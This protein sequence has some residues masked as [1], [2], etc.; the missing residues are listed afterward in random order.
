MGRSILPLRTFLPLLPTGLSAVQVRN[1]WGYGWDNAQVPVY[2][3]VGKLVIEQMLHR[4]LLNFISNF[5][6]AKTCFCQK[7]Q[8][9]RVVCSLKLNRI[10]ESPGEGHRPPGRWSLDFPQQEENT[11]FPTKL[12]FPGSLQHAPKVPPNQTGICPRDGFLLMNDS[13]QETQ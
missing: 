12:R 11:V 10:P 6:F 7:C 2:L 9:I 3:E 13:A 1:I 4:M 8:H 5:A